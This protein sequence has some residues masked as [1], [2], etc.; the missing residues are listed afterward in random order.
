MDMAY[1][2]LAFREI[3]YYSVK[4]VVSDKTAQASEALGARIL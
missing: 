3:G 2:E 1:L 4:L